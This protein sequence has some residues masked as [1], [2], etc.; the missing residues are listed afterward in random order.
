MSILW[1]K[2]N[3]FSLLSCVH[4]LQKFQDGQNNIVHIAK[5]RSL[6]RFRMVETASPVDCNIRFFF[7]ELHCTSYTEC[8]RKRKGVIAKKEKNTGTEEETYQRSH[9]PR[10]DKIDTCRHTRDSHRRCS[11]R[12][13]LEGA[14]RKKGPRAIIMQHEQKSKAKK[15]NPSDGMMTDVGGNKRKRK[16]MFL[17]EKREKD[18]SGELVSFC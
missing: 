9:Q 2:Q 8:E 5:S 16:W 6:V 12:D 4:L 11:P 3:S 14:K 17:I 1:K 15:L 13:Q 7:I 10:L 18:V